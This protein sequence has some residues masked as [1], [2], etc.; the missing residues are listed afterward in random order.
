MYKAITIVITAAVVLAF[1]TAA[2][3]II[4]DGAN[5]PTVLFDANSYDAGGVL[6]PNEGTGG[7]SYNAGA[8]TVRAENVTGAPTRTADVFGAGLDGISF[9]PTTASS[10]QALGFDATGLPSGQPSMT[11]FAVVNGDNT[12]TG[13]RMGIGGYGEAASENGFD[14][15]QMWHRHGGEQDAFGLQIDGSAINSGFSITN[16]ETTVLAITGD[17]TTDWKFAIK[18]S[19]QDASNSAGGNAINIDGFDGI[20]GSI[21]DGPATLFYN[22]N[23]GMLAWFD[24]ALDDTLR[25]QIVDDLYDRYV[26]GSGEPLLP[27]GGMQP[28]ATN[29]TWNKDRL[30]DWGQ[31][32]NWTPDGITPSGIRANNPNHTAI[33]P[34]D[35]NITGLTNVSTNAPV[36]VNRIEFRNTSN[37]FVISGGGS[38]NLAATTDPNSPVSP[39]MLVQG[40]HQFQAHVN[41]LDNTAIDVE[42]GAVLSFNDSLN[43]MGFTLTKTGAGDMLINNDLITG[44]GSVSVQQG[45]LSG[46]GNRPWRSDQRR[47]HNFTGGQFECHGRPRTRLIDVV[48]CGC[49]E[50]EPLVCSSQRA[51]QIAG[52]HIIGIQYRV[53]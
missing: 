30:G 5:I 34:D 29:F 32:I 46:S 45:T 35:A 51:G 36:T 24:S 2:P 9:S 44:G 39:T 37:G 47:R 28:E 33:F 43:L 50:P 21:Y 40:T 31:G 38:V 6:L 41:L 14:N 15:A 27:G 52:I 25:D 17:G 10:G 49:F 4:F 26:N 20:I 7:S 18:D 13:N 8:V 16:N 48:R 1:T 11:M 12:V 42:S 22:G 3:A 53:Y 19:S 23:I